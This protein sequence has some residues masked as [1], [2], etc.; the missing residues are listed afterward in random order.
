MIYMISRS[1]CAKAIFTKHGTSTAITYYFVG[2][3]ALDF[4]LKHSKNAVS[5]FIKLTDILGM[6]PQ[7]LEEEYSELFMSVGTSSP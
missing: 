1:T 6:F 7:S 5:A 4:C 3:L 2:R